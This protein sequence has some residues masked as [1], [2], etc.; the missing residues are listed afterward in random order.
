MAPVAPTVKALAAASSPP[1][2]SGASGSSS[3]S[4]SPKKSYRCPGCGRTYPEPGECSGGEFGHPA[5]E[6]LSV[7]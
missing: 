4:S 3:S 1:P 5:L 2:S 6:L 7:K